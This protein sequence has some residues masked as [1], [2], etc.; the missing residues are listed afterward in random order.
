MLHMHGGWV[1]VGSERYSTMSN[2][3]KFQ[4]RLSCA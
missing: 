1:A 4:L 3:L 2:D